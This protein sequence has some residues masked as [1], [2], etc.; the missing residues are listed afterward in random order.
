M[1]VYMVRSCKLFAPSSCIVR[2]RR[3]AS[4]LHWHAHVSLWQA[5]SVLVAMI[6]LVYFL[7]VMFALAGGPAPLS[8]PWLVRAASALPMAWLVAYHSQNI[9]WNF[10]P[11]DPTVFRVH[12]DACH[13]LFQLNATRFLQSVVITIDA[14]S[15]SFGDVACPTSS[16]FSNES[17]H[18]FAAEAHIQAYRYRLWPLRLLGW[19]LVETQV[20]PNVALEF[21][22]TFR[23]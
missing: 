23:C 1:T 15:D 22:G 6:M 3:C 11:Y 9:K 18:S 16:G 2:G 8:R 13:G 5:K 4:S 19:E 14:D 7:Q 20:I 12:S 21:G 10:R 17:M